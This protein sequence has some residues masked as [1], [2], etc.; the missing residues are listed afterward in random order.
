MDIEND[1]SLARGSKNARFGVGT[2]RIALLFGSAAIALALFLTPMLDSSSDE[3]GLYVA[4]SFPNAGI[5][6]STTGSVSQGRVYTIRR[7]VLQASPDDVCIIRANG[8]RS[9]QC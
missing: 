7:S 6:R 9:G 4:Q 8:T 1:W 2:L 3:D 5:D